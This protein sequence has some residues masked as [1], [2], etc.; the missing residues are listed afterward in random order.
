MMGRKCCLGRALMVGVGVGTER[1]EGRWRRGRGFIVEFGRGSLFIVVGRVPALEECTLRH[2]SKLLSP[3]IDLPFPHLHPP[4]LPSRRHSPRA[5]DLPTH[6][7][8]PRRS[9]F[10]RVGFPRWLA[11]RRGR[12][13][14][15]RAGR[16]SQ[17]RRARGAADGEGLRGRAYP[18]W[19][20]VA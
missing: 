6:T 14:I 19:E 7:Q 8:R 15:R 9:F 11:P 5:L 1:V 10:R 4:S 3:F 17:A 18:A 20:R 13:G 2:F 12:D 16:G